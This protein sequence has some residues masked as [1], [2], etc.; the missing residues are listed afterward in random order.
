MEP[1]GA[2]I[3]IAKL[4][5]K[6]LQNQQFLSP[7][8][9]GQESL[10]REHMAGALYGQ[11]DEKKEQYVFLIDFKHLKIIM[12]KKQDGQEGYNY[13]IL[14]TETHDLSKNNQPLQNR[15]VFYSK[16]NDFFERNSKINKVS[17]KI[18]GK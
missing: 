12:E 9:P 7:G 18:K 2:E 11:E 13:Y 14:N 3:N 16:I 15:R 17:L 10:N 1:H 6:E 8:Y 4:L 5:S